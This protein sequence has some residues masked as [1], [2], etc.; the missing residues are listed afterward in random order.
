M[1]EPVEKLGYIQLDEPRRPYPAV[2]DLPQRGVAAT[3]IPEAVR[4][5]RELRVVVG[6]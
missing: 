6:V 2:I 3:T 1:I 5:I 4:M